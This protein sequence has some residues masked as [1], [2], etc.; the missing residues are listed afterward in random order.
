M[1]NRQIRDQFKKLF[2]FVNELFKRFSEEIILFIIIVVFISTSIFYSP[3]FFTSYNIFNL[4]RNTSFTF[5]P[6]IGQLFAIISGAIDL[7]V[8]GILRITQ[9]I[10]IVLIGNNFSVLT[11]ILIAMFVGLVIGGINGLLVAKG[12]LEPLIVTLGTWTI[13]DGISL[14][15]T[16]GKGVSAQTTG[17]F[18]TIG[19]ES[20]GPVYYI[21]IITFVIAVA[22]GIILHKTSFGRKVYSIGDNEKAAYFSGISVLKTKILVFIISGILCSLTGFLMAARSA[23]FKPVTYYGGAST[24]ELAT[25]AAVVLGG[26]KMTGGRGTLIGTFLGALLTILVL[27]VL[28][29]SGIQPHLQRVVIA[30]IIIGTLLI[31]SIRRR[32][33]EELY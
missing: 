32:S 21:I 2:I 14:L 30:V 5:I 7:S 24:I 19:T 26:A 17:I 27:N 1:N 12:R 23:A 16:D 3:I 13:L 29:L 15:V 28:V 4:L 25:I 31:S 18:N 6:S 20:I 8:G 33:K 10:S 9:L 22:M 11:T